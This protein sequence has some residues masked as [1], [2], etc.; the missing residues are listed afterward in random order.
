MASS[1]RN[2]GPNPTFCNTSNNNAQDTESNAFAISSLEHDSKF[3]K[4]VEQPGCVLG[5]HRVIVNATLLDEDAPVLLSNSISSLRTSLDARTFDVN[6]AK[7]WMRLI[8]P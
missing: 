6:I 7:M 1:S 8:D 2:L 3:L 4:L 5:H